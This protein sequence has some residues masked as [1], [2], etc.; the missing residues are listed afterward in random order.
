M[1]FCS[2]IKSTCIAA[3]IGGAFSVFTAQATVINLIDLTQ[4]PTAN[5]LNNELALGETVSPNTA[6]SLSYLVTTFTFGADSQAHIRSWFDFT[7]GQNRLGVEIQDTG[8][9]QTINQ[10]DPGDTTFTVAGGGATGFMAGQSVTLI[11]RSYFHSTNDGM[12]VTGGTSD[13]MLMNVWVN[14]T[15]SATE[16]AVSPGDANMLND[17][18]LHTLWNSH[19]YGFLTQ[20]IQNQGTPGTGGQNFI[21]STRIFTGA[22][23]T[24]A[25]A[26]AFA[27]IPEPSALLLGTI[28]SMLLLRRRR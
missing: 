4:T 3:I 28:G 8:L 5:A 23:A 22:D 25:N 18:D 7:G 1:F 15:G 26:L 20:E 16:T 9:V 27:T 12:R 24:F 10:G 13:D 2:P 17:G 19:S 21:T 11:V 6:G 14:P